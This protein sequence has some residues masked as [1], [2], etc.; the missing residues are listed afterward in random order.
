MRHFISKCVV[1]RRLRGTIGG[2][3]MADLP[4]ERIISSPPFPHGGVDY[5]GPF[6]IKQGRK[7]VKLYGVL[8]TC[9][10]SRAVHIKTANSLETVSFINVLR[11]FIARRGPVCEIRSDQ[12]TNIVAAE[13]ELKA[14]EELD[15]NTIQRSPCRDFN[16]DWIIQ[17]KQNPPTASHMREI[18]F[19]CFDARTRP[20]P[21]R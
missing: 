2:Q 21:R 6:Y 12:G 1:C 13:R 16:A 8:F 4:K 11:R 18:N 14:L 17:W 5:F 10:A 3:K 20:H 7:D 15:H 19:V 9:L